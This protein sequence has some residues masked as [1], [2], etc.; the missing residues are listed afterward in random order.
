MIIVEYCRFGNI[1]DYL[2]KNRQNFVN[3]I[4][5]DKDVIDPAIVKK[6]EKC[7]RDS[8]YDFGIR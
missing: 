8:G 3:Q 1:L 2:Q 6:E 7:M 4:I 5:F